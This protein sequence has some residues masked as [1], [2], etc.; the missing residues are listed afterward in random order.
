MQNLFMPSETVSCI[1]QK[2]VGKTYKVPGKAFTEPFTKEKIRSLFDVYQ[3]ALDTVFGGRAIVMQRTRAIKGGMVVPA[4]SYEYV[5]NNKRSIST[6]E[7]EG[8][9]AVT[10]NGYRISDIIDSGLHMFYDSL[11]GA[12]KIVDGICLTLDVD[13]E[14]T[15]KILTKFF[16]DSGMQNFDAFLSAIMNTGKMDIYNFDVCAS[17]LCSFGEPLPEIGSCTEIQTMSRRAQDMGL[18]VDE[19][20][21]DGWKDA[22]TRD[23]AKRRADFITYYD[24]VVKYDFGGPVP[25]DDFETCDDNCKCSD[26]SCE[27][28]DKTEDCEE[29]TVD[30]SDDADGLD[31]IREDLEEDRKREAENKPPVASP[32]QDKVVEEV[33]DPIA[34]DGNSYT[35]SVMWKDKDGKEQS[36]TFYGDVAKKMMSKDEDG[37]KDKDDT[38]D[39]ETR[40]LRDV[41]A[42][43]DKRLRR[44][45]CLY[46]KAEKEERPNPTNHVDPFDDFFRSVP[47]IRRHR[48]FLDGLFDGEDWNNLFGGF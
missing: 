10:I 29:D 34:S 26:C 6:Y 21:L 22:N 35:Y 27:D 44:L 4:V 8:Y 47:F 31:E 36:K 1:E 5:Y 42:D 11:S 46:P 40:T 7:N 15:K 28:C 14:E 18:A 37:V 32:S 25:A 9:Y 13:A 30:E 19:L 41:F 3:E 24:S 16:F 48:S 43:Y 45:E 2:Y 33:K 38:D 20:D 23:F 39:E 17:H 12:K